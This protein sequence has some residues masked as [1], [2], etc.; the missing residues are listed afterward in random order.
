MTFDPY[1]VILGASIIIGLSYFFNFASRKTKIPSVL[2]LISTGIILKYVGESYGLA[3]TKNFFNYLELLGI[4]G[5]IMIVLEAAVELNISK[6]KIGVIGKSSGMALLVLI[7]SSMSIAGIIMLFLSE[8]FFNSVLY[9]IP[10]SVVSSAVLIPSLLNLSKSKQE[11]LVY[12]STF[13]DIFGI[14]LFNFMVLQGGNFL[15]PNGIYMIVNTLLFSFGISYLMIF[16][17]SRISYKTKLFFMMAILALFYVLGKKMDL[18]PLLMIFI[19]GIVLNNPKVFFFKGLNNLVDFDRVHEIEKDFTII[20]AETAFVV[21]T[22]FFVAFGMAID[23]SILWDIKVLGVGTIILI[24]LYFV[25]FLNFKVFIRTNVFPEIF[26]AP[27]GLITILL[28]FSIPAQYEIKDFSTGIL[29]Y[30]ILATSIVM[31]IALMKTP[32]E[33]GYVPQREEVILKLAEDSEE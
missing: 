12:E 21:R 4:I 10:L 15:T 33:L 9:A 20:T 11:F 31:M 22:F 19:F 7:L 29:F 14:L 30:V 18:S 32:P 27:R 28:F 3:I 13:S 2:F 23:F 16:V 25:R 17:F 8:S 6:D 24:V 1:Y 5:L 26:L